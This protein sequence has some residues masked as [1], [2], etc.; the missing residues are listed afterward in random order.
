M[1]KKNITL[2][3]N[4]DLYDKYRS[5]CKKNNLIVSQQFEI[6]MEEKVGS[7][8]KKKNF[9]SNITIDKNIKDYVG[10]LTGE[11]FMAHEN[12]IIASLLVN[13]VAPEE[14]KKKVL[15][16]NPFGYKTIKSVSK[17]VN[18]IL[19]RISDLDP[20]LLSKI[21]NDL[22]G[23]GKVVI[24]YSIYHRDRLVKEVFEELISEKFLI[25]DFEFDKKDIQK[26]IDNKSDTEKKIQEF[27]QETKDKLTTVIFN[28][29]KE[30]GLIIQSNNSFKLNNMLISSDLKRYYESKNEIRFLKGIGA[31]K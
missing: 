8:Y 1:D 14:I 11:P 2:N 22:S 24:L 18:S 21:N 19:K 23:D 10:S 17:R 4:S 25:R 27:T 6:M 12:K 26:F 30:S 31:S 9:E 28:I 5:Y 7:D 20:L 15:N 13:G 16:E 29:L 3:V